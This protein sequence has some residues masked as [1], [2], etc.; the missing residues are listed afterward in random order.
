MRRREAALRMTSRW[1]WGSVGKGKSNGKR[2]GKGKG[3]MRGFFAALRMQG[4]KKAV[5]GMTSRK[6]G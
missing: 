5:G 2:N 4:I 3:K 6:E 1:G